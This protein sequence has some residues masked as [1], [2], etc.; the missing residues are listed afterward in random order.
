MGKPV[1]DLLRRTLY[2]GKGNLVTLDS[3]YPII[4]RLLKGHRVNGILDAGASDGRVA[5]RFTRLF[6]DATA[7]L[8]EPNPAYRD[9][10]VTLADHDARYKPFHC[11]LSDRRDELTYY[12]TESLGGCSLFKPVDEQ[13][14]RVS[15]V[16]ATT[17]DQWSREQ[18]D[19]PIELMKFDIQGAE[20]AA[21]RGGER[22]LETSVLMI[23]IE[24]WFNRV[25]EGGAIFS[26]VDL[27][28]RERGFELYNLFSPKS[29]GDDVLLW[30]NAIY[31]NRKKL[32]R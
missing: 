9:A 17:I 32:G 3:P 2:R 24:V 14:K 29:D 6:P 21:L 7:Y 25:Y 30:G 20:L 8:F 28:L 22:V 31:W 15:T 4:H 27:L 16:P 23:Y 18:G 26:E 13:A 19:P 5:K 12:E 11:A 1:R 10:L